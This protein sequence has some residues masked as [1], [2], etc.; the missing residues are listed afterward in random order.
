MVTLIV[1]VS[2][3]IGI[4]A[5]CSL[6][7]SVLYSTQVITLES[8][9][10][11][12]KLLARQMQTLKEEV[13][14]PLSAILILNTIANTAGAALAGWAAGQVWGSKSLW[15]FSMFF[16]LAIL[17]FSE[18]IPK[19]VGA[20]HWRGLW[21]YSL[22]PLHI[23]ILIS[24]PLIYVIRVLT[25]LITRG[26][27]D[28]PLVS[29]DEILAAARLGAQDGEI[30][31][32]EHDL[33]NNIIKLEDVRASD[34]MTP[35]T[36]MFSEKGSR[37]LSE[38]AEEARSWP[39]TRVPVYGEDRED[40][41][42]YVLKYRVLAKG[43]SDPDTPLHDL[44]ETVRY[45]PAMANALSLL[46]TFLRNREQMCLVVDEWGGIAGLITLEDVLETMVGAEIMDESDLVADM[47][48]LARLRAKKKLEPKPE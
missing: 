18:I 40:I 46:S 20:V 48:E 6:L 17:F 36:V 25:R 47:Q 27:I 9:A 38:V 22:T 12:H 43:Q 31:E 33:I 24:L 42:G 35:R 7:E 41:L 30:S 1:A 2:L 32:L 11:S 14:K 5:L 29:E 26:H 37:Q 44:A 39:Y 4:S 13:E 28:A 23:M 15:A 19:T 16:T 8:A 34:I 21:R 10:K 45:V 3:S